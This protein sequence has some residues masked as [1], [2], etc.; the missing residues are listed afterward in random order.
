M[1]E[2]RQDLFLLRKIAM[3]KN[4]LNKLDALRIIDRLLEEAQ[5]GGSLAVSASRQE[6][7]QLVADSQ[8][9]TR[10]LLTELARFADLWRFFGEH[11]Q[12]LGA[13][14]VAGIEAL[15][16]LPLSA[17]IVQLKVINRSLMRR[18]DDVG[19]RPQFRQ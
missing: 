5:P 14:V 7:D 13:E 1:A 18:L 6:W 12:S 8:P 2:E 19:Q 9:E 3:D 16:T 15:H 10:D 17:R 11:E 4:D